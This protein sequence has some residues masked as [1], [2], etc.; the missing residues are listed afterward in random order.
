MTST[1]A[2]SSA[3]ERYDQESVGNVEDVARLMHRAMCLSLEIER[4]GKRAHG[5]THLKVVHVLRGACGGAARVT[6]DRRLRG[7]GD[8]R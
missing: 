3:T 4:L 2:R 6:G 7:V 1:S 5:G 8:R